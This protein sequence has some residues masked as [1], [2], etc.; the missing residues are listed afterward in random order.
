MQC[1]CTDLPEKLVDDIARVEEFAAE[2]RLNPEHVDKIL[3]AVTSHPA[4]KAEA[5]GEGNKGKGMVT[6]LWLWWIVE[7]GGKKRVSWDIFRLPADVVSMHEIYTKKV[8]IDVSRKGKKVALLCLLPDRYRRFCHL[9]C[10]RK[11]RPLGVVMPEGMKEILW[12]EPKLRLAAVVL[13]VKY[14][15]G[16]GIYRLLTPIKD[17]GFHKKDYVSTPAAAVRCATGMDL[18]RG[19]ATWEDI[20]PL[21]APF[22]MDALMR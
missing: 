8:D 20:E 5:C 21:F 2:G 15:L 7:P 9:C 13:S 18:P 11:I 19:A 12:L 3:V 22:I 4:G 16:S 14:A 6:Y 17:F 1:S 10:I